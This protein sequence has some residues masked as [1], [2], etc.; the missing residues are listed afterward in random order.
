MKKLFSLVIVFLMAFTLAACANEETNTRLETLLEDLETLESQVAALEDDASID[1]AL[2]TSLQEELHALKLELEAEES[3]NT[4]LQEALDTLQASYDELLASLHDGVV[5][6]TLHIDGELTTRSV[7]YLESESLSAFDLLTEAFDVE[8]TES[9]YGKFI[10]GIEDLTTKYGNYISISKNGEILDVGLEDASYSDQDAFY[11]EVLWWDLTAQAV[12]QAINQFLENQV[13][14]YIGESQNY[15]V[16]LGLNQLGVIDEYNLNLNDLPQSPTANDYVK[17]IFIARA[18]GEDPD[19]LT[20]S[21]YDLRSISHPYP[22]SL[23]V[24]ALSQN[25]ALDLE[26]FKSD[27]IEDL[28]DRTLTET[29]L[30]SLSLMVLALTMLEEDSVL[31]EDILDAITATLYTSAY[32]NNSATFAH[33]IMALL[34]QGINPLEATYNQDEETSFMDVFL[35]FHE[36]DGSFYYLE[37]D[38]SVDLNFSTPQA[39]LALVMYDNY[40]NGDPLTHPFI[41]K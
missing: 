12:D 30:D 5:S 1:A 24:M 13:D 39:F 23:Q 36:G 17:Q 16:I 7:G 4:A 37:D 9:E 35:S 28:E 8:Y 2:I 32:G 6:F 21:L 26:M 14:Q 25:D 18:L 27:Y 29:D 3:S 40:L 38:T 34:S 20:A 15:Y 31:L 11:F 19:D 10:V 22:T 33:V 41:T